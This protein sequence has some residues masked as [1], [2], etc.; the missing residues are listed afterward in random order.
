MLVYDNSTPIYT[1]KNTA[2]QI[3]ILTNLYLIS[4]TLMFLLMHRKVLKKN[5]E[6]EMQHDMY[7]YTTGCTNIF[8]TRTKSSLD[9]H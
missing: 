5:R 8:G 6:R 4:I 7:S 9:T 3:D 2:T 1:D